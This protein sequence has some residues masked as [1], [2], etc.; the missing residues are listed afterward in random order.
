MRKID[1]L[2]V[3]KLKSGSTA[4]SFKV[5]RIVYTTIIED[6]D[7]SSKRLLEQVSRGHTLK[8]HLPAKAAGG[9]VRP[10]ASAQ[11]IFSLL[12]PENTVDAG[13]GDL[14]EIFERHITKFG[15]D[16]A[17]AFYWSQVLRAIG[18]N[19]WRLIR[20]WGLVGILIDYGRSKLGF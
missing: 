8:S 7:I 3:S 1:I 4:V 5:G 11:F 19:I 20:K 18:P 12:S 10:P 16:R 17:R 2:S 14:Q 6:D 13:L 15:P 9:Q